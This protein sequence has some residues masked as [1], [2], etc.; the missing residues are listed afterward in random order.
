MLPVS[1]ILDRYEHLMAMYERKVEIEDGWS[2]EHL[3]VA[4]QELN[5]VLTGIIPQ[6]IKPKSNIM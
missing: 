6:V 5:W 2:E 1:T 3:I 4:M